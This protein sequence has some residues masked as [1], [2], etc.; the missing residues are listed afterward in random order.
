LAKTSDSCVFKDFAHSPSK[1]VATT[2]AVRE[3]YPDHH[4]VV[5]LEL[6]TYSSLNAD[7]LK[8][9]RHSLDGAD[10]ALVFYVPESLAI[11]GL[12]TISPEDI[13]SAFARPDLEVYTETSGLRDYLYTL[14]LDKTVLLLM[15]SGNY[16][17]LDLEEY[18]DRLK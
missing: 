2:R 16:G 3:Q 5:C 8:E 13:R 4:L 17:G 1:V 14:A 18:R 6:H 9:Y 11:K 7:F 12:E 10:S 15:S